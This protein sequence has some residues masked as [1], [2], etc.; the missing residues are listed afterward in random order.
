[1]ST[2]T[3]TLRLDDFQIQVALGTLLG[4]S[5]LSK[6]RDG[7]NYHLSCYHAIRQREWI[8]QKNAWLYPVSRPIHWCAYTDKRDGKTRKGG[9][10]HTRSIPQ[11]TELAAMLYRRDRVKVISKRYLDLITN[12]V[13]LACLIGD[14][15]SWD[16]A[17]IAIA[18]KQ[19]TVRENH[20]LAGFLGERFGLNVTVSESGKYPYVR[21][22]AISV[23][24]ARQFVKP[25]LPSSLAYK[26][27]PVNYKTTLV[28]KV[29]LV[30]EFCGE[31]F[32]CYASEDRRCCSLECGNKIKAHGYDTRSDSRPCDRCGTPFVIYNKRQSKCTACRKLRI[33]QIPCA[34]CKKPVH[35]I[36]RK[37]CSTSC[38]VAFGHTKR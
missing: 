26:L 30:C 29:E 33:H 24:R 8:E 15:G 28:G 11:L 1:M 13:A 25:F 21:I 19:F 35:H 3:S 34:V 9:R 37:T 4:D 6:P 23:E 17:G 5:S 7:A 18:S 2:N 31:P 20:R 16:Q 12:P 32:A 27:G 10:F 38:G 14:D 22:T 36:A